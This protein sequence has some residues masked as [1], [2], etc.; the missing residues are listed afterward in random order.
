MHHT[1]GE[2]GTLT[3]GSRRGTP[4]PEEAGLEAT[5]EKPM[6]TIFE[7]QEK[8]DADMADDGEVADSAPSFEESNAKGQSATQTGAV[9]IEKQLDQMDTS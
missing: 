8:E 5:D 2:S 9:K 1:Q 6:E 4:Q 3:P 7:M